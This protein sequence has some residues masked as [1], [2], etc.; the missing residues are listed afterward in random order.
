MT[1]LLVND[2][3][4]ALGERTFWSDLRD[5]FGCEF[6]GG[7][8]DRL[9]DIANERAA[10]ATLIIRNGSYFPPIAAPIPTI[11]LVQ[12]ILTDPQAL[13]TQLRVAVASRVIVFNSAY[14]QHQYINVAFGAAQSRVIPLPV[15]FRM[16]E[17]G[18]P[19]GLQQALG[20]PDNCIC[21]IGAC[22]GAAGQ[23]KGFDI[24]L[25]MARANPD[26]H[27]VA[28]FKDAPPEYFPPNVRCYSRLPHEELV[29]VIG[30]CRVG[31]CTSRVETQHLAGIEM[32]ACGLPMVAPAVGVYWQRTLMPGVVIAE[33]GPEHYSAAIRAVL[34]EPGDQAA[35]RAHWRADFD[36]PVIR[37]QWEA[38]VAEVECSGQS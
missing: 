31:L 3:L 6:V 34:H 38:L 12:D 2:M 25:A 8:F 1:R 24:L 14:T 13:L 16:F 22:Q 5:W 4:S 10:G 20:L 29:K 28:V 11:S 35:I 30:A 9:A 33:P 37:K 26:L 17:P 15:D 32:G 19:M 21:W 7:S 23:V 18:N 27:F 36:K